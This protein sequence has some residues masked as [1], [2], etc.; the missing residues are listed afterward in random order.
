MGQISKKELDLWEAKLA[1][2]EWGNTGLT[3]NHLAQ[4]L[5]TDGVADI[6]TSVFT[7]GDAGLTSFITTTAGTRPAYYV[8]DENSPV[9]TDV[10]T[11]EL[12]RSSTEVTF[13]PF[14]PGTPGRIAELNKSKSLLA[15]MSKLGYSFGTPQ[16]RL[17]KRPTW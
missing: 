6:V 16:K 5:V 4:A 1:R 14:D 2:E 3:S 7:P 11:W 13:S 8:E 12:T 10:Y 17:T 9:A 15:Y